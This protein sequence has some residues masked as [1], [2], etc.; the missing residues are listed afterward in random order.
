MVSTSVLKVDPVLDYFPSASWCFWGVRSKRGVTLLWFARF[1]C[2]FRL[3]DVFPAVL[4]TNQILWNICFSQGFSECF[5]SC[6]LKYFLLTKSTTL[7]PWTV[8]ALYV[9]TALHFFQQELCLGLHCFCCAFQHFVFDHG[10]F[11][12]FRCECHRSGSVIVV[13]VQISSE[14]LVV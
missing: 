7:L 9:G 13:D 11:H 5:P 10:L 2:S 14:R 4:V 3:N 6:L 12:G 1:R 8:F